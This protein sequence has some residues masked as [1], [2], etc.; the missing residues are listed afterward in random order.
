[1]AAY[2]Q[3]RG[4]DGRFHQRDDGH[5]NG[6]SR[7]EMERIAADWAQVGVIMPDALLDPAASVSDKASAST[8]W[9]RDVSA[10][11]VENRPESLAAQIAKQQKRRRK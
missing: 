3:E 7:Q 8:A 6:V 4:D 10:W 2:R 11:L 5:A 1:M 9:A